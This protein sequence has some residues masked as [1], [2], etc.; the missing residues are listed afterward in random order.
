MA[1]AIAEIVQVDPVK[2]IETVEF[3]LCHTSDEGGEH[4]RGTVMCCPENRYDFNWRKQRYSIALDG[5]QWQKMNDG[6][7][8]EIKWIRIRR[9]ETGELKCEIVATISLEINAV[10]ESG[11]TP[12]LPSK[13]YGNN[14]CSPHRF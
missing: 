8:S 1:A 10:K 9:R 5:T 4:R 11:G 6:S 3:C 14:A 7:Q 13:V 12:L 2:N